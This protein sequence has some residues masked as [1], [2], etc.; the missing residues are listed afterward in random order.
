MSSCGSVTYGVAKELAKILKPLV[1]KSPHHI[2]ST[3][4]F[5]EQVRHIKLE[6]GECLSS[7]DVSALFTSVPIDPALNIIKD[8]LDKDT[9]LKER[10]IME[11]GDIILLLEFCLKNTYF[12]FQGQFYEQVEGAAMGSPVSP[13]VANL[14]MEYLEQ[15]A[16]S[17]APHPPVFWC[18][19]VDDTFVIHKE[20]N[21]QGFLQHINSVDP[22]IRF[23]V[24]DNKED[25][26]IPFLDTIV[27]P[28][29]Y[30]SLSISVYRKPTHTEQY[31]QWDSHHHL[32]AKFSV[33]QTLSHRASTVCSNPELL[34][35]EKDH[36]RKALIKCKYPKWALDK[37][38]KR[39]N[40]SSR[41]VADGGTNN[42]QS[43]N[44]EVQNKG[45]I[46]IPYTQGLCESI[47]K[48][49]GRY[50]IQTHFKGGR[51]I[52]NILVSPK[53]K[54]PVVNQSGAI[55]WY[56]CGD[57]ACDD[58]YIGET[59]R[60]FG[61]RYKEHLKPPSAIHHHSN[62]TGHTT[63]Q[64]NFQIIGREGH[65]LARNIKESIYIRVNNPT[66]NNNIGKFNLSHIW[67]RAILN[68]KGL[69]LNNHN[70]NN[71]N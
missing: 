32:S 34:Q 64:N 33:I 58:E 7:Y 27:K 4:D 57:L 42:A 25:G 39:L 44:Y 14:Y 65:N 62:Q 1:G 46:V 22:A 3:Q 67:D 30:G 5:V 35:K 37:V 56:Q 16:L 71:N 70:N 28:E 15:K 60:T 38:D 63:N 40:R 36:P 43:A 59:S 10:T 48:I 50:G 61:E 31:L 6:P 9:T 68:T 21:K 66:L 23:T 47:K 13:I 45:H 20:A 53:D 26:S 29:V 54:D 17:T 51:T 18:R 24:E 41:Q 19:Y 55:Y 52:K 12:S 69:T 49:C 11:V 2:T 8:L